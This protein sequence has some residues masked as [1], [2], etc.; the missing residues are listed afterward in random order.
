MGRVL[1]LSHTGDWESNA[2]THLTDTLSSAVTLPA[3]AFLLLFLCSHHR[4]DSSL[5]VSGS[6]SRQSCHHRV[7]GTTMSCLQTGA[8]LGLSGSLLYLSLRPMETWPLPA[9]C[10]HPITL[11]G[12]LW[13]AHGQLS[14]LD[15][16][17]FLPFFLSSTPALLFLCS[18]FFLV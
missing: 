5:P 9:V 12:P 16:S 14:V 10:H 3:A 17:V 11:E 13:M 1:S 4:E 6:L 7:L 2:L 18:L 15:I 8:V